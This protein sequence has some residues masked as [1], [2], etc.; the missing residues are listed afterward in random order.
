MPG[1]QSGDEELRSRDVQSTAQLVLP[2]LAA[3]DSGCRGEGA[4][5]PDVTDEENGRINEAD[6]D[7]TRKGAGLMSSL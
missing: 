5:T 6:A 7:I 2:S 4:R 3:G 1:V